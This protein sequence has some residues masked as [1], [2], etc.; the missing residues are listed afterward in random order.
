MLK[1]AVAGAS[2]WP[3]A[4]SNAKTPAA[5]LASLPA[6]RRA[7]IAAVRTVVKKHM[8][9]GFREAM[10]W[11]MITWEVPLSRYPH[12]PNGQ[13]LCY[14]SLAAQKNSSTLYLMGAYADSQQYRDLKTA[15]AKAG[16]KFDMGKSCLHFKEPEDLELDAIGKL[17]ASTSP[18]QWIAVMEKSRRR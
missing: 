14:V 11:G 15:F 16:K 4:R 7:T 1:P 9:K 6:D 2:F 18:E 10:N 5:Y 13:P 3:M 17:I 12:T 8:P